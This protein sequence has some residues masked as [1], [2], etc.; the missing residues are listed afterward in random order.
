MISKKNTPH[1]VF[2]WT[3]TILFFN[4][5]GCLFGFSGYNINNAHEPLFVV[6]SLLARCPKRHHAVFDSVERVV[7]TGFDIPAG[8]DPCSA[9]AHNYTASLN[10]L[11][12]KNLDA[13]I[14][15]L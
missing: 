10:I 13:Q 15:R 4:R 8:N 6:E 14:F 2:F 1:G 11:P 3:K 7:L 9:L 5:L 12:V